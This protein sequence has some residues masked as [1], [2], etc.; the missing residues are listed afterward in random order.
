MWVIALTT[1]IVWLSIA[2][3]YWYSLPKLEREK[4]EYQIEQNR[5]EEKMEQEKL[6][7][8]RIEKEKL[9]QERIK[10]EKLEQERVEKENEIKRKEELERQKQAVQ[11]EEYCKWIRNKAYAEIESIKK[12]ATTPNCDKIKEYDKAIA[13]VQEAINWVKK[14]AQAHFKWDVPDYMVNAYANNK[15]KEYEDK[16]RE[17]EAYQKVSVDLC[18]IEIQNW[19]RALWM[20]EKWEK[21]ITDAWC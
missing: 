11:K 8:E 10:Q 19:Y 6:E 16:I 12:Q 1:L 21:Y 4:I 18:N 5:K 3:Y 15:K 20:I 17:I 13:Q 9:E 2:Y 14:E 7:Q